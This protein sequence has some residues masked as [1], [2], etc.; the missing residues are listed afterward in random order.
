MSVI[1]YSEILQVILLEDLSLFVL[2]IR[3]L[4]KIKKFLTTVRIAII[5]YINKLV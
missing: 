4:R 3:L 2:Y 1:F 5:K